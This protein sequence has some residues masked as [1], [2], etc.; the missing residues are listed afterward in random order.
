[1]QPRVLVRPVQPDDKQSWLALWRAYCVELDGAV[2]DEATDGL[3]NRILA[4]NDPIRCLVAS[5]GGDKPS[6]FAHY[7]L[8]PHTFSL[9]D[10]CYLE[11]IFVAPA[12]R[13]NG[14]GQALIES[15]IALGRQ[16]GWRRVYWHTH[17]DNRNARAL[18]DRIV[19]RTDY[20]R[21][22]VD[23]GIRN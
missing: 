7:V 19:H 6:A 16:H 1:M 4:P 15:L 5:V 18:Y 21:Y 13:G 22:D 9:Q 3:W 2:S 14:V 10:V 12:E 23:F 11:D 17:E 8:H 20:I